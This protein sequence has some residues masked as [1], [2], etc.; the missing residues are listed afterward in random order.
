MDIWTS[1]TMDT[2]CMFGN[3]HRK[4]DH[5][6]SARFSTGNRNQ[7]EYEIDIY[8]HQTTLTI[9]GIC[10]L[11]LSFVFKVIKIINLECGSCCLKMKRVLVIL[12][13]VGQY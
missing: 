8:F 1:T 11:K 9:S 10:A 2:D 7:Y 6:I 4:G 13:Y 5:K 3:I 12:N